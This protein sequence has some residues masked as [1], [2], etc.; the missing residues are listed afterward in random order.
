M[1]T[2]ALADVTKTT[3]EMVSLSQTPQIYRNRYSW[4]TAA[5]EER[6]RFHHSDDELTVGDDESD[7]YVKQGAHLCC[8][9]DPRSLNR[10]IRYTQSSGSRQRPSIC[11]VS[12]HF[13]RVPRS[14]VS[15]T[16]G[17][18]LPNERASR[19]VQDD[20]R[21]LTSLR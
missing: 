11:K 6:K 13:M 9:C 12:G 16:N 2:Y 17:V 1:R 3:F 20:S 15:D 19:K 10:P 14:K 21:A 18:P 7:A 5:N 8:E 4:P